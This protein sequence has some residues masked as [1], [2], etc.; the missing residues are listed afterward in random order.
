MAPDPADR[1]ATAAEVERRLRAW[2]V[3]ADEVAEEASDE[4]TI[5]SHMPDTAEAA[6]VSLPELEAAE[7]DPAE[8][9]AR[10]LWLTAGGLGLAG[11]ALLALAAWLA[12]WR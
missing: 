5:L 7:E 12:L 9:S 6:L 2:S 1:P 4:A 8:P 11:A 10:W 3:E